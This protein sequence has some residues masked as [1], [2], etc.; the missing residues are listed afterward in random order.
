[1]GAL[2]VFPNDPNPNR[3]GRDCGKILDVLEA[4][5]APPPRRGLLVAGGPAPVAV[6]MVIIYILR[7]EQQAFSET[8]SMSFV[9]GVPVAACYSL[10]L[11][12][13]LWSCSFGECPVRYSMMQQ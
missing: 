11:S 1:M 7:M 10:S 6:L 8:R 12:L 2:R 9:S 4:G 13:S 3:C 5:L